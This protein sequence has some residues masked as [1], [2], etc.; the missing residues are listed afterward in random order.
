MIYIVRNIKG[1]VQAILDLKKYMFLNFWPYTTVLLKSKLTVIH[2]LSDWVLSFE[3][4]SREIV[5]VHF[6]PYPYPCSFYP[7][8]SLWYM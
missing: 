8:I 6:Y 4:S 3:L 5:S 2:V 7:F 1:K